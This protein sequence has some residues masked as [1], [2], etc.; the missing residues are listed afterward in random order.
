M[1][2]VGVSILAVGLGWIDLGRN[3]NVRR[4]RSKIW[5]IW[6]IMQ[7]RWWHGDGDRT[8]EKWLLAKFVFGTSM[9]QKV[10]RIGIT[11][12]INLWKL[13]TWCNRADFGWGTYYWGV[14]RLIKFVVFF[15]YWL[16]TQHISDFTRMGAEKKKILGGSEEKMIYSNNLEA[17]KSCWGWNESEI[18]GWRYGPL[19]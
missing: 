4:V 5:G 19:L 14:V 9:D 8:R 7:N 12:T 15:L 16:T 18:Y 11:M 3:W 17:E 6:I 1:P 2:T 10:S 13:G